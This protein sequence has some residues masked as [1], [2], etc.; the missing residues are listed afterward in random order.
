MAVASRSPEELARQ[1]LQMDAGRR[2]ETPAN[3]PVKRPRVLVLDL[4]C[5]VPYYDAYFCR[6]LREAG[7][8]FDLA[9]ISYH[10]DRNLFRRV[11]LKNNSGLSDVVS[12]FSIRNAPSRQA[13]KFVEFLLNSFLLAVRFTFRRPDILHTEFL[14][15]LER[16]W[17]LELWFV[18]YAKRLHIKIVHTV[19]N[20]LPQGTGER[21]K[22]LYGR[23]YVL[24][25][26]L[27]CQNEAARKR[28]TDEFGISPSA[29]SI[30]PHGPLFYDRKNCSPEEARKKLDLPADKTLV[31][32]QGIVRPYKGVDFLLE[33]WSQL[34][35]TCPSALLVIAGSGE[36]KE[37]TRIARRVS[38]LGLD[39]SVRLVLRF[40]SVEEVEACYQ[41]ADIIVYPYSEITTSGALMTSL[42]Y[43]KAVV[44]TNL[45]AFRELLHDGKNALLVNYGDTSG[46]VSAI[47]RLACDPSERNR[48]SRQLSAE[49][50]YE[51]DPWLSIARMTN[52][53]YLSVLNK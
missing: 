53:C 15:L 30:I 27:I 13:L 21:R 33:S 8:N 40:L 23:L 14:P 49:H 10:Q 5:Y 16:G 19:H 28:L 34:Q 45:P 9:A 3:P 41:A 50:S 47:Q 22:D 38:E 43:G 2:R 37:L 11:G 42:T 12:R 17:P 32:W 24:A 46:L 36:K 25:D 18:A 6:G 7:V 29:I 44:A 35:K 48:L 1:R 31:L 4:W 51:E 39:S 52:A 26:A 20:V